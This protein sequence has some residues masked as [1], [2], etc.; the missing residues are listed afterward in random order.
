LVTLETG[1]LSFIET[2]QKENDNDE[3]E[4]FFGYNK[5]LEDIMKEKRLQSLKKVDDE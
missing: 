3:F 4:G 2:E 5:I 1:G